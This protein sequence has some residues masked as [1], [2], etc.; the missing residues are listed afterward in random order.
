MRKAFTLIELIIVIL[1]ISLVGFMVFSEVVKHEQK[2]DVLDPTTLPSAL[3]KAFSDSENNI[4]FFCIAKST[5]CYVAKGA[6]IIPYEGAIRL[7]NNLEVYKVDDNNRLVKVDEFGRVK[8]EKITL[9][10]TLYTNGSN[11]QI[12]LAND[13]GIY[14]LPSYLGEPQKV[15]SLDE[16]QALWIK[17][18]YDL[19]DRGNYY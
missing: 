2:A 4:E 5:D 14:Y 17:E 3:R 11:T 13:E 19:T 12:V 7:G 10:Y 6:E 9:R 16:A 8:D 1:I 15:E 18:E